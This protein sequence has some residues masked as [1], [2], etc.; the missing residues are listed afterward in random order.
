[1]LY[2]SLY[3]QAACLHWKSILAMPYVALAASSSESNL[4]IKFGDVAPFNVHVD[5]SMIDSRESDR[6]R[7]LINRDRAI[8]HIKYRRSQ[9]NARPDK[10]SV[11]AS[12]RLRGIGG[13][14]IRHRR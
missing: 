4:W 2:I 12:S 11:G 14:G 3:A 1:M 10:R 9:M 5:E 8:W 13:D 7:V 6:R